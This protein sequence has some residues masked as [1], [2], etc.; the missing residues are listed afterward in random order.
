[1]ERLLHWWQLYASSLVK[2]WRM[3]AH[4]SFCYWSPLLH[5]RLYLFNTKPIPGP[6]TCLE[7]FQHPQRT[8][9]IPQWEGTESELLL[10]WSWYYVKKYKALPSFSGFLV[11][12]TDALLGR[13]L[14]PND[15]R[16]Q[17]HRDALCFSKLHTETWTHLEKQRHVPLHG[18]SHFMANFSLGVLLFCWWLAPVPLKAAMG[19]FTNTALFFN[20]HHM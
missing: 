11:S 18:I 13:R 4:L 16:F 14:T 6:Q 10:T 20:I 19:V 9:K 12:Q 15:S 5:T 2:L 1:M 8:L 3:N 17:L 7:E